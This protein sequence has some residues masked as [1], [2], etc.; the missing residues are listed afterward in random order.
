MAARKKKKSA[1]RK[2]AQSVP[3]V[4]QLM[5]LARITA[6]EILGFI[7]FEVVLWLLVLVNVVPASI[8]I[9]RVGMIE[10][11]MNTGYL[12]IVGLVA[13]LVASFWL[14]I[15]VQM[16]IVRLEQVDFEL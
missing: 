10:I 6:V 1:K 2:V 7:I 5:N 9:K 13:V 14:A 3:K 11:S 4:D 8:V 16:G 15:L 12:A